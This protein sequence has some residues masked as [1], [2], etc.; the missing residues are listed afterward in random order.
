MASA[1]SA[2]SP[3]TTV[4]EVR[5]SAEDGAA[6]AD[7]IDFAVAAY[8]DDGE[9]T[10]A[11]LP[12]N[13]L[14]SLSAI[15]EELRRYPGETGVIGMVSI[16]EDFFVLLRVQGQ[17]VRALISDISAADD[18]PLARQVADE[19]GIDPDD[20]DPDTIEPAGDLGLFE[21]LGLSARDLGALTDDEDAFPDE[22]LEEIAS[23]LGFG[24]LYADA[25]EAVG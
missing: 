7:A 18:W 20:I 3:A 22:V 16:D 11:G 8:Q 17:T 12:A 14:T 21:D 2:Q 23:S 5:M 4:E 13:R 19:L 15:V 25:V 9:W 10:T 1:P 24:E 6:T